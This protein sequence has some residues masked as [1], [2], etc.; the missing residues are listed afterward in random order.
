METLVRLLEDIGEPASAR[1]FLSADEHSDPSISFSFPP[2]EAALI[3]G[4]GF[5][6]LFPSLLFLQEVRISVDPSSLEG[7]EF[8]GES[9]GGYLEGVLLLFPLLD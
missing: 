3:L 8:S 2:E 1:Q 4:G 9:D 6:D 7:D 5:E